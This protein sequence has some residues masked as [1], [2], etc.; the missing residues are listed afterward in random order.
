MK[1]LLATVLLLASLPVMADS[2]AADALYL[3]GVAAYKVQDYTLAIRLFDAAIAA[4][5]A[6]AGARLD[7]AIS[8]YEQGDLD[9]AR[10]SFNELSRLAAIPQ[11]IAE[12]VQHYLEALEP[13]PEWHWQHSFSTGLGRSNNANQGLSNSQ[14][15]FGELDPYYLA[16][17][18][19]YAEWQ[20]QADAQRLS[21]N[22]RRYLLLYQRQ[23]QTER[24]ANQALILGGASWQWSRAYGTVHLN[25][26]LGQSF[27]NAN[28]L[29]QAGSSSVAWQQAM[30]TG[31]LWLNAGLQQ[32]RHPQDAANSNRVWQVGASYRLPM[33]RQQ[34]QLDVS[35]AKDQAL[36][37]R[38]GGQRQR[39]D[40]NLQAQWLLAPRLVLQA[41][42]GWRKEVQSEAF[43]G[44]FGDTRRT[45][46]IFNS[47]LTLQWLASA[48]SSW[49]L[50][51][52]RKSQRSNIALY[53]IASH[54]W[55]LGWKKNW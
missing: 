29:Y 33:A 39:T 38:P 52:L 51:W 19:G 30:L 36:G 26:Q 20:Y 11:P 40:I 21:D 15:D 48:D 45:D 54:E 5:P 25:A 27:Q 42:T 1:K 9:G 53:D 55:R 14:F 24:D 44:L 23:W 22:H 3:Q 16:R 28:T 49:Q 31:Q 32:K 46:Q 50:G 35:L 6:H 4:N 34:W 47:A 37:N 17:A 7:K 43:S 18:D 10:A 13:P 2:A 12:L 41:E 8:Q